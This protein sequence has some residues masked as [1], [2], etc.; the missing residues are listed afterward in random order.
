MKKIRHTSLINILRGTILL[1]FCIGPT[2]L[3]GQESADTTAIIV[4]DSTTTIDTNAT[5]EKMELRVSFE[6]LKSNQEIKLTARTRAKADKKFQNKYGIEVSFYKDEIN[7]ANFL[8]K[9]TSDHKG[10]AS[11]VMIPDSA[12]PITFFAVVKDHP[13]YVDVEETVTVNPSH[14]EMKLEDEDS[15][16]L[17]KIFIG[18]PDETGQIIPMPEVECKVYV[19]RLFGLLQVAEPETSDENGNLT[20]E[21][22][23][24][25][26]GD[27]SGNLI[28]VAKIA[29]H[30][31]LGNVEVSQSVTWGEPLAAD[32]FYTQRELWSAR[33]NSPVSLILIVNM[34]LLG[35]WGVIAFIFLEIYRINKL[36]KAAL[37]NTES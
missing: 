11:W 25:I 14:V 18:A 36:G 31:V 20:V 15:V 5:I 13:D 24:G 29:E 1:F 34:V 28:V 37:K 3:A 27:E 33:S 6:A 22:P 10:E 8:G 23:S 19:K 35:I 16:H 32:D 4:Q 26:S 21:F 17:V 12:R 2:I 7:E 30:E 9:D